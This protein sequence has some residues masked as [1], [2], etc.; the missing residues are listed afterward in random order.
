MA[1]PKGFLFVD[2]RPSSADSRQAALQKAEALS[3]AA[4][5]S[6]PKNRQRQSDEAA[7]QQIKHLGDNDTVLDPESTPSKN[8]HRRKKSYNVQKWR[9]IQSQ[10][11][12]QQ[13]RHVPENRP[14]PWLATN[15]PGISDF[16]LLRHKGNTDPFDS[17]SIPISALAV[18]LIKDDRASIVDICWPGEIAMRRN[19]SALVTELWKFMPILVDSPAVVHAMVSHALYSK[20]VRFQ[21][22][23]R[24]D[25]DAMAR[26]EKHRMMAVKGLRALLD[27]YRQSPKAEVLSQVTSAVSVLY[28][29]ADEFI[30]ASQSLAR[31]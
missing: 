15:V 18:H 4:R 17:T 22:M 31:R 19:R 5:V 9:V 20:A 30:S 29:V 16:S 8:A 21:I 10:N 12:P 13:P 27:E 6:H 25:Q 2:A 28:T 24:R 1:A 14:K 11:R 3:H 23:G 26:A 7:E